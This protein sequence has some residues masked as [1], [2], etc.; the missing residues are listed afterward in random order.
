MQE[1]FFLNIISGGFGATGA[2]PYY[3]TGDM[4]SNPL[5]CVDII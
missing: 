3:G 5:V 1:E 2:Y 4:G